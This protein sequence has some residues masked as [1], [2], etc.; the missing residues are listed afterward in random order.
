MKI[1][2]MAK[3]SVRI[4]LIA[5]FMAVSAFVVISSLLS[6]YSFLF[7]ERTLDDIITRCLPSMIIAQK[8]AAQSERIVA[9][10][11]SLIAS[12]DANELEKMSIEMNFEVNKLS[13]LFLTL[14]ELSSSE[15]KITA[16]ES[17]FGTFV[18]YIKELDVLMKQ[19]LLLDIK[20]QHSYDQLLAIY[21]EFENF[22]NPAISVN[23]APIDELLSTP[24]VDK[25]NV[26][27]ELSEIINVLMPLIEIRM[28]GNALTNLLLSV[29]TEHNRDTLRITKLKVRSYIID[30]QEQTHL[31]IPEMAATYTELMNRFKKYAL[32]DLSILELR[33]QGIEIMSEA[34][35]NYEESR[36]L[37]KKLNRIVQQLVDETQFDV[38]HAIQHTKKAKNI[39]S[40]LLIV[41]A[42]CS[43]LF[44][45]IMGWVYVERQVIRP[46]E[47]ISR[48]AHQIENG[49][50]DTQVVVHKNDEIGNFAVA[51]NRMVTKRKH[52]E[53]ALLKMNDEL[54]Q[55]V[56]QRTSELA[57]EK[58][59]LMV[60]L[61]SIGDGVITTDIHSRVLIINIVA[62][63]LTGWTQKDA[64]GKHIRE[65]FN[66]VNERTRL[67][68]VNKLEKVLETGTIV[69]LANNTLLIS[70]NGSEFIISD[71]GAPI[72]DKEGNINGVILVF[73]D[74]TQRQLIEAQLQQAQKLESIGTLAGGIA[75][76]F[77][78]MI[79]II[80]GNIS[81]ALSMMNP[82]DELFMVLS[83]VQTGTKQAQKLTQQLLTFA[84][85][86]APV[87]KEAD[88]KEVLK[89][90]ALFVTRGSKVRCEFIFAEDLWTV[91]ID[92]GQMNQSIGNLV[93]NAV[94]AM[95]EGGIIQIKAENKTILPED[96]ILLSPGNYVKI[97]IKDNGMGIIDKHISKIFDPYFTTKQTGSGL[98]LA[99]TYSII[100]RHNG[101]I[102]VEST[103]G[104]GTTFLIYLPAT[105]TKPVIEPKKQLAEIQGQGKILVMD[106]QEML[107]EMAKR[108]FGSMGYQA[109]VAKDGNQ[110]IEMYKESLQ[111][112]HPFDLV[113]LDLTIPGGMGGA[114]AIQELLKIN[115][116]IKAI[117]SSGYSNDPV[118]SNYQDY[119]FCGV[120]P[121]PF[122]KADIREVLSKV[123]RKEENLS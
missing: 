45:V 122:T 34:E 99:T 75:H 35:R 10:A 63:S 21:K 65:V 48:A 16:I 77:N 49:N 23:K 108:V 5:S 59:Q 71:S 119:G 110:A 2:K 100:K 66:I 4:K 3:E 115:P 105:D 76:D 104:K 83:D 40:V 13:Q 56:M 94:Q 85:G 70:R 25:K 29:A 116:K 27:K 117:V 39:I 82:K 112:G 7:F 60:T 22:I 53:E 93:I 98:G 69:G 86:G 41:V 20:E 72:R 9:I 97:S 54:E 107:L 123:F 96:N 55:R 90:S 31:L 12:S 37:S 32:G 43:I 87:K 14:K 103:I 6:L 51:F 101:T 111:S 38:N 79:G 19:K 80:S 24:I 26:S 92:V 67:Y 109:H 11:P 61:R 15:Q 62:E 95:P 74:I 118:M 64:A 1:Q 30:I 42:V 44:S 68:P 114:E 91:S 113:V 57:N 81:Y 28:M 18:K 84:K 58:E 120:I 46:I 106:D 50:L 36:V 102:S 17:S 88:L 8:I 52:A 89:E 73:R 121:K 78:N 33:K 47:D